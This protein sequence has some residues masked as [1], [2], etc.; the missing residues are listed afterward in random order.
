MH[1]IYF[2]MYN[3]ELVG[4][5]RKFDSLN[6][7]LLFNRLKLKCDKKTYLSFSHLVILYVQK[8]VEGER[9]L[10]EHEETMVVEWHASF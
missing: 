4:P 1:A 2:L 5:L 8:V 10:V 9:I 6:W 3:V 7:V